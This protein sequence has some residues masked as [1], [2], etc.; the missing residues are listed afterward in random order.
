MNRGLGYAAQ[1]RWHAPEW[2]ALRA[3]DSRVIG[4]SPSALSILRVVPKA[5]H[6]LHCF[7]AG[8]TGW[9]SQLADGHRVMT[10][11][12]QNTLRPLVAEA[13]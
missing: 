5:M 6:V 8:S 11:I 4:R 10:A 2:F 3:E 9:R 12:E 13:V 7:G 1:A